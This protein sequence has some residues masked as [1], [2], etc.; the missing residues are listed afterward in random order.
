MSGS[1]SIWCVGDGHCGQRAALIGNP[2]R[3]YCIYRG[4][5]FE[6]LSQLDI[7]TVLYMLTLP[8]SILPQVLLQKEQG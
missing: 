4:P 5:Y 6:A 1:R 8:L 3:R 7:L 2:L